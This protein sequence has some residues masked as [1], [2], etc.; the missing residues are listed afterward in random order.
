[1][2][3]PTPFHSRTHALSKSHEWRNWAGWLAA[4]NYEISHEHEYYVIRNAAALIDVS[5]LFKHEI[6]GPQAG[7]LVDRIITREAT[8]FA[9]GQ[10]FYPPWCDYDGKIGS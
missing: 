4:A 2:P 6:I 7:E 9:V 3:I 8:N 5:P 10:A 1:M